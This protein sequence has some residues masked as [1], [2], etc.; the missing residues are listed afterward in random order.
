V[1]RNRGFDADLL[2]DFVDDEHPQL[3]NVLLLPRNQQPL[4]SDVQGA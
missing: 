4:E 3:N 2:R 1:N